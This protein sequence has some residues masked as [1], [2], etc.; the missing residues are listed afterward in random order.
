M[1]ARL[2]EQMRDMQ[3]EILKAFSPFEQEVGLR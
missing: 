2:T 3:T 1:E